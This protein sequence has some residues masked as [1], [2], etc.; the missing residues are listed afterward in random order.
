MSQ[1]ERIIS[2]ILNVKQ[3]DDKELGNLQSELSKNQIVDYLEKNRQALEPALGTLDP[4]E[5]TLGLIHLMYAWTDDLSF[6]SVLIHLGPPLLPIK[7][8]IK[9]ISFKLL[10]KLSLEDPLNKSD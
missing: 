6:C 9:R 2:F 10:K 8:S 5:H 1:L 7:N 3:N 4:R